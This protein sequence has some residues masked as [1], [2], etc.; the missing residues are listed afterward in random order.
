[1]AKRVGIYVLGCKVNYH[2]AEAIG[3]LFK[4]KGYEV[5][6]F[7]EKAD[8]YII[9]T[10]TV[11]HLSDRKS[12]QM[13]RKAVRTNPEA[14]VAVTGC[15]AQTSPGEV[16]EIP[17]VDLVVGTRDRR[18]IVELVE[19]ASRQE[20]PLNMVHKLEEIKEFEELPVDAPD[21]A[22][23]FFKIQEGCN[24]FCTY[25]IIPYARGPIRSRSLESTVREVERLVAE[26][27]GEIVLTGIHV[28]LYGR[29]LPGN[30]DLAVLLERLVQIE[31]LRR[32]RV[33]SLDPNDFTPR[34]LDTITAY[35]VICPHYHL[36]LQSGDDEVLRRMNR[37]YT[38]E[39]YR[40]LVE[41]L[42]QRRPG[43][44]ITTDII[45]GFP[46]ETEEQFQNTL[47][48]VE[49][50]GFSGLH[51]F[52]YSPR[53]GTPAARYPEQVSAE[54]KE[55]RSRQLIQLGK[56]LAREYAAQFLNRTMEVLVEQ[57]VGTAPRQWT[58]HTENYLKVV[59]SAPQEDLRG[60]FVPV[61][62]QEV[63]EDWVR[64]VMEGR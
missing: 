17:G 36:S 55:R 18:R 11:T 63:Q 12:R 56:R 20:K 5:V 61:R 19:A 15:Y 21:R 2:E 24:R 23:A 35:P 34:L 53:K 58:G 1:M 41:E 46:G 29:D 8:V 9:H 10:C 16:L 60:Q 51:V 64:G 40:R 48:F 44:A 50:I 54:E 22:R 45:V 52:K 59:F 31:G 25:C 3:S 62:L 47:L 4:R 43:C 14:V 13:I 33:S 39:E 42:R 30:I 37:R 26:G 38:T 6:P 27:F 28:G 57:E 32:L 7:G 49:Q